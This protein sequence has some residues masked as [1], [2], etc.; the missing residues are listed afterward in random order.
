MSGRIRCAIYT[1]KSSEEG[2]EQSF[3]SLD[4]QREACESFILSQRHEGWQALTTKYD[5][6]GFSGGTMDRPALKR[7]MSD[8]ASGKIN[9]VVVYKVDRLTRS[10][11]D[12]AKIIEL[13]DSRQV[14]FV[15]VTQQFN[16]TTSMGRL[17]LNVLLSFAQFERE[18]TGERIRDKIAASKQKGMWMGG[19]VP[20]GYDLRDR[21]L[22]INSEEAERV[23][24]IYSQ[25]LRLGCVSALKEH[26]DQGP[27]R[28][29][30]R[31][32]KCKQ[33]GGGLFSR[34]A[35]YKILKNHLYA[36]EIFHKGAV[37]AGDHKAIIER[38]QWDK[39]QQMLVE[40]RQGNCR[41]ARATKVSLLTG[42][43]FDQN[44]NRFTPTHS[45][46][47][48]KRYRY[49]TSQAVIRKADNRTEVAR[50]PAH[51]LERAV[52]AR[53]LDFLRSPEE[54]LGAVKGFG[55]KVR[56][57]DLLLKQTRRKA[58]DWEAL[59]LKDRECFLK[60]VIQRVI[61]HYDSIEIR[62]NVWA[63]F[64]ALPEKPANSLQANQGISGNRETHIYT[65][66]CP[67]Q[68]S[69]HG[70]ELRLILG[71]HQSDPTRSTIAI[72]R[73]IA[74]ARLW[75]NQIISG[76]A[77]G[78]PDL[79]RLHGVSRR[80]VKNILRCA[81]LSPSVVE[82]I[83][84][85]KCSTELTLQD[86]ANNIPIEWDRQNSMLRGVSII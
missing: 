72:I 86:L 76:E 3:N 53:V 45:N 16:T 82:A 74:R 1:R 17:T 51:E 4:A 20:L 56:S 26:L 58:L 70:N 68:Q 32:S 15:S 83:L 55:I 71:N 42:I 34:G 60:A 28:S 47:A 44:D 39:V 35:L 59:S 2:L 19:S 67:F 8:I 61:V 37:Y 36:G 84:N 63:L 21:K 31:I 13:F 52:I 80:Y 49:Y 40:N 22:Y 29:K 69:R 48:G 6:G 27:V 66:L 30:N 50:I 23:R 46:K 5:D 18:V 10:L 75:Y 62:V 77:T 64:Q 7:L 14:S 41:K 24:E 78:I 25:Y 9:T 43:V 73:A 79:A 12:F 65:L 54:V 81:S 33:S 38:E 57:I 11:A 85:N